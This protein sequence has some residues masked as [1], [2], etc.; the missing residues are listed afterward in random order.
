MPSKRTSEKTYTIQNQ[1]IYQY[2][3]FEVTH[4]GGGSQ[5]CLTELTMRGSYVA[6]M[7]DIESP[8]FKNV[9]IK[10]AAPTAVSSGDGTVTFTG[11]YDPVSIADGDRTMLFMGAPNVLNYPSAAMTLG[12]C[13]PYFRL[14]GIEA[15][16][17][18]SRW[19][20]VNGDGSVNISDV[21]T[22]V[23]IIL[24]KTDASVVGMA[25]VNEDND[26]N[27]SD[28]TALVNAILG[29]ATAPAASKMRVVVSDGMGIVYDGPLQ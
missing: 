23:N 28:V 26:L 24:G 25:D 13:R 29:K 7:D 2:F 12:S 17:P 8:T 27:I 19:S 5:V 21:T 9:T 10:K 1:G 11:S 3:R 18:L 4:N 6:D 22:L 14:N 20:D 16:V 15:S